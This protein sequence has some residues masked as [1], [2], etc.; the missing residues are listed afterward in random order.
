MLI[1]VGLLAPGVAA[2]V[3]ALAILLFTHRAKSGRRGSGGR[4][5]KDQPEL[6][7]AE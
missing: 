5:G 3:T 2:L 7:F 4:V 1:D 6:P